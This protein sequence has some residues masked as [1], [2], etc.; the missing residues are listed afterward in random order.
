MGGAVPA[1]VVPGTMPM[2]LVER[3]K[4]AI[5]RISTTAATTK[6]AG[7]GQVCRGEG[8]SAHNA[9]EK[10]YRLSIN[11]KIVE[12]R[13]LIAGKD[14][15]VSAVLH[16]DY[17][18]AFYYYDIVLPT[19]NILTFSLIEFFNY[20]I[21]FEGVIQPICAE[22]AIKLQSVNYITCFVLLPITETVS[23]MYP[24]K[25]ASRIIFNT[26]HILSRDHRFFCTST[27]SYT[28]SRVLLP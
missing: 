5:S 9:I 14:S 20:N 16:Y 26:D 28:P 15:K 19:L 4:V 12:L 13:E 24:K 17:G 25:A 27:A 18:T 10:R 8:R 1:T 6:Q 2:K 22:S 21:L 23:C 11:D 3:E 7:S